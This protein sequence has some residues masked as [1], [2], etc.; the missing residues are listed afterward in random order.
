MAFSLQMVNHP[1]TLLH[2]ACTGRVHDDDHSNIIFVDFAGSRIPQVCFIFNWPTFTGWVFSKGSSY[3]SFWDWTRTQPLLVGNIRGGTKSW[4]L[5]PQVN[6]NVTPIYKNWGKRIFEF[7]VRL[8]PPPWPS[9]FENHHYRVK[10]QSCR[11]LYIWVSK[12]IRRKI[13]NQWKKLELNRAHQLRE[14]SKK[15]PE[16]TFLKKSDISGGFLDFSLYW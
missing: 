11:K 5:K 12:P 7:G 16:N 6:F 8:N 15:P 14:K 13:Q 9:N 4:I 10:N 1:A 2:L 3:T